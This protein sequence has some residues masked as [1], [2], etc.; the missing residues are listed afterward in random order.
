MTISVNEQVAGHKVTVRPAAR[1]K[2]SQRAS[3]ECG[4][5]SPIGSTEQVM[6]DIRTH[7]EAVLAAIQRPVEQPTKPSSTAFRPDVRLTWT[8]VDCP[9]LRRWSSRPCGVVAKAR[10]R[11]LIAPVGGVDELLLAP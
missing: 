3:C 1:T 11:E 9:A 10:H 4:W 5:E 8:P 2:P 7:L 6:P